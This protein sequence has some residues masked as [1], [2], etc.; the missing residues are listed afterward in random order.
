MIYSPGNLRLE[1]LKLD[2]RGP[3]KCLHHGSIMKE[4]GGRE[5][6]ETEKEATKKKSNTFNSFQNRSLS[7]RVHLPLHLIYFHTKQSTEL[8]TFERY[9]RF[10]CVQTQCK[11]CSLRY[12]LCQLLLVS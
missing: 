5:E 6:I 2:M 7:Q 4:R 9:Y 1:S 3:Q 10:G 8:L 12:L 11:H